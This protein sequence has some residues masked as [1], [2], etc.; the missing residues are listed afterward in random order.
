MMTVNSLVKFPSKLFNL[1]SSTQ[2]M[3][4]TSHFPLDLDSEEHCILLLPLHPELHETSEKDIHKLNSKLAP[5]F[6]AGV[7]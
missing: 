5:W 1:T 6:K 7:P 3:L 2:L 4:L